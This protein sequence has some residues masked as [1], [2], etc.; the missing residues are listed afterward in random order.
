MIDDTVKSFLEK[1][2]RDVRVVKDTGGLLLLLLKAENERLRHE[3]ASLVYNS[4]LCMLFINHSEI[5]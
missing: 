4:Q 2:E 5:G 3:Q 1:E